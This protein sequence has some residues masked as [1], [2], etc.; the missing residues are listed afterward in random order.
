MRSEEPEYL[1]TDKTLWHSMITIFMKYIN[2]QQR[3]L[4]I[5]AN[6][7]SRMLPMRHIEEGRSQSHRLYA[8]RYF[9]M[10][11]FM[12]SVGDAEN[13]SDLPRNS[14]GGACF[15]GKLEHICCVPR[16]PADADHKRG[17]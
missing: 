10:G 17:I 7:L 16:A 8:L 9:A 3:E 6:F 12:Y 11:T 5:F 13:L 1:E 14:Q 15:N 2:S 4:L